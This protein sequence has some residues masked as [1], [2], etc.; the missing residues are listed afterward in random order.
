[1]LRG[2]ANVG[3]GAC[4]A[5]SENVGLAQAHDDGTQHDSNGPSKTPNVLLMG[6]SLATNARHYHLGN[7]N[8]RFNPGSAND[9][10][11]G[12]FTSVRT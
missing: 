6:C 7:I 12:L 10:P 3:T 4:S 2:L 8:N 1:M 9:G 11:V 5:L